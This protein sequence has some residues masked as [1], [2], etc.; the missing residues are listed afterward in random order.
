MIRGGLLRIQ[1]SI[2]RLNPSEKKV[3]SFIIEKPELMVNMTV[4][5]LSEAS[6][7]SQSA[8]IRLCKTL[9]M[10]S[11]QELK[12]CVAGDL[13]DNQNSGEE[14]KEIN[15][16]SDL[17]T[18][19]SS[20]T[21]N[22]VYSL[23][24]TLKIINTEKLEAAIDII[25][26]A[27]RVD[28][29]GAGASQIVAQDAQ[30]KF[31]RI[32]KTCTAYSDNH[33]QLTSAV[34]LTDNDAAVAFSNSGET[35]QIV[36]CIKA[37]KKSGAKTIGITRYGRNTLEQLVDVNIELFSSESDVRSAAT[38]SRIVQLNIVDIIFI[39]IVGHQYES[40]IN[41]LNRSKD[42]IR[43]SYRVK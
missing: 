27:K 38:S 17:H 41:Y 31:M 14:Y 36:E 20:V 26:N 25:E 5:E 9:N 24:E 11:Y 39:A 22:N 18:I 4:S 13:R 30:T 42:T 33:L 35:L 34:T 3:A 16:D 28:F 6:G 15:L 12:L 23:K 29:Y 8:I 19:I 1:E 37:A 21:N 2:Q 40:S 10:K 43:K 7:S 32:N